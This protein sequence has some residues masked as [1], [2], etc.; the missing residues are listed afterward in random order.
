MTWWKC[1]KD[2]CLKA[3]S[4]DADVVRHLDDLD[5][6]QRQLGHDI[7]NMKMRIEPLKRLVENIRNGDASKPHG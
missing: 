3:L 4:A 6:R 7:S 5:Q 2:K 1:W